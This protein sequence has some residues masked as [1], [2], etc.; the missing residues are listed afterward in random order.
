[1]GRKGNMSL[2]IAELNSLAPIKAAEKI[3][4]LELAKKQIESTLA[5]L[6]SKLLE[7][8]KKNDVLTLKTGKYTIMRKEL[9]RFK[10]LDDDKAGKFLESKG[11][12]VETKVVLDMKYMAPVIKNYK[13]EIPGVE[14]TVTEYIAVRLAKERTV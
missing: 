5:I 7:E 4:E 9:R 6:R 13:E 8:T 3:V 2:Q 10:V 1:V 14:K 11:V 12:P